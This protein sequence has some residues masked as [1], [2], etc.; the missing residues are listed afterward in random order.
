MTKP[1]HP[2]RQGM[3]RVSDDGQI[4]E[5]GP[6]VRRP[7]I[8]ERSESHQAMAGVKD[9]H[10]EQMRGVEVTVRFQPKGQGGYRGPSGERADH[11]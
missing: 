9:L 3:V 5:V 4:C 11:G 10:I 6:K 7:I 8:A 1:P 2:V